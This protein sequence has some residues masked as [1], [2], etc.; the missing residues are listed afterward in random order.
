MIVAAACLPMVGGPAN[1]QSVTQSA[2]ANPT[3]GVSQKHRPRTSKALLIKTGWDAP[4]PAFVK[5]HIAS[6]EQLPF[7][8]VAITMSNGLSY[9]V[10]SQTPVSYETLSVALAPLKQTT[11]TTLRHNFLNIY[12]APAGDL[13]GDWTVPLNNFTNLARAAKEAGVEGV[14]YDTEEYFG[15]ALRYPQNCA[16]HTVAECQAQAQLR[17]KQVMDAMRSQWPSV[18]VITSYGAWVSDRGTA[19]RLSGVTYNDVAWA[20]QLPGPFVI[21]MVHS[22]NGTT[23]KVIDGGEIYTARTRTQFSTIKA[24]QKQGMAAKSSLIPASL[25]PNWANT[26]SSAFGVYDRPYI[27]VSMNVRTWRSTLAH[28]LRTTDEYVWAYSERYDW[29]GSGWPNTAVPAK[30]VQATR[31]AR[32]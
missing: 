6:M 18:R 15:D 3:A 21:G 4:S 13:Y 23:A 20:N 26:V 32:R 8:G 12:A 11:F 31:A 19:S 14:F 10:Q 22:A 24:W 17:G 5:S 16:N 25:K 30:W 9:Q 2:L 29:W 28:A 27:G 7:D 1:A